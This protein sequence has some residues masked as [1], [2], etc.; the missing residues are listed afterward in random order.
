MARRSGHACL[1]LLLVVAGLV[2]RPGAG[3]AEVLTD[4]SLGAKVTRGGRDARIPARL[5]Q[6]QGQ[7]LFHS[8][9]RFD[10]P[11]GDKV[12]FTG[13]DGLEHVIARVTG[14]ERSAI[15][16]TLASQVQGADLWLLNPAGIL[17][18][19]E[20][21]LQVP[22]AFHAST[23][24]V[25]HFADGAEFRARDPQGGVLTVAE[26]RA[27]GFLGARP[28]A[29]GVDRSVLRVGKGEAL[30]LAGGALTVRGRR[31]GAGN[32]G[33]GNQ[34][35]TLRARAG[36]I[37]L[38]ALGGPG[39][40]VPGTGA[41]TGAVT[42]TIRLRDEAAVVTSG[43]GGGSIRIRAGRLV[44]D[45][46]SV[47]LADNSGATD[48][49]GGIAIEGR[50]VMFLDGAAAT[51]DVRGRG[52]GGR[53]TVEAGTLTLRDRGTIQINTVAEGKG[54]DLVADVDRL[55]IVGD[56][57]ETRFPTGIVN[58]VTAGASGQ[59]GNVRVTADIV[60]LRRGGAIASDTF[61]ASKAGQVEVIARKSLIANDQKAALPT[62][63]FSTN[64]VVE[65][66]GGWLV[67]PGDAGKV[68]V[69]AG[70]L[71]LRNHSVISTTT[72]TSGNAGEIEV[73]TEGKLLID[74]DGSRLF[75]GIASNAD[76]E[77]DGHGNLVVVSRGHAGRVKVDAGTIELRDG[78][79]ISSATFGTGNAGRVSVQAE[80]RLLVDATD[81]R[82]FTGISSDSVAAKVV[83][84]GN[85]G[86]VTVRAGSVELRDGGAISSGTAGPGHAGEVSV[87]VA[88]GLTVTKDG[89]IGTNSDGS[90][91]AGNVL[92][93]ARQLTVRD[94]GLIGSSG[95]RTGAAGDVRL[96]AHT[97]EVEEAAIRTEGRGAQG[98]RIEATA[99]DLIRL[100]GAEV[101]SN[102]IEPGQEASIITL[103][104]PLIAVNA[105]QV[106]SLTGSGEPLGGSGLARLLGG[107]TVISADSFVAASSDVVVTGAEAD[108]GARLVVP[109]GTFLAA[110]DLLRESCAARR[111]GTA[112][113]F[114]ATGRGGLPPD[115]AAPSP[116]PYRSQEDVAS[117]GRVTDRSAGRPSPSGRVPWVTALGCVRALHR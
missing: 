29:I 50:E 2:L 62:G 18:G 12:T 46:S 97:L 78:G 84:E 16:G 59:V 111:S 7:N 21:R 86:K 68:K 45:N 26:P 42:G 101:T 115:P 54:G 83:A 117:G 75:T 69:E 58:T 33:Q 79:A 30:S 67:A 32:D 73:T 57:A 72:S 25:L 3:E 28:A 71:V 11:A 1:G 96:V 106:T 56:P 61:G 77:E 70:S 99:S 89:L 110:G 60:E 92:V 94:D 47:I 20:A 105:S 43:D 48:A 88:G 64:Q 113:S 51:A 5:G 109:Q 31:G 8:F 55:R 49:V 76:Y 81:A 103:A 36:R 15:H 6:V 85:A 17:F 100:E 91:V 13:P 35:G 87:K 95:R 24:D 104:A 23:A 4:G 40:V 65:R 116:A 9:A 37:T 53:L 41:A 10:I 38:A 27:F 63:I 74:G 19:P 80:G 107:T 52:G 22:G 66:D 102:G 39:T 93:D 114:T 98:G 34:P 14:G 90:G 108:V 82:T 44:A 112:S